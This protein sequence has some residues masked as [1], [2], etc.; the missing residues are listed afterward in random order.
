MPRTIFAG[1]RR[2]KLEAIRLISRILNFSPRK[3]A[4]NLL[5]TGNSCRPMSRLTIEMVIKLRL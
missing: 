5:Q 3:H 4:L 2:L 1:A